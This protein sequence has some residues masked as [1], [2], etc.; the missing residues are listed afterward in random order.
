MIRTIVIDAGSLVKQVNRLSNANRTLTALCVL[1]TFCTIKNH[2][3]ICEQD[4]VIEEL[5]REN[6]KDD[7]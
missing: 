4:R 7:A 1:L 6:H 2:L 3:D 5:R